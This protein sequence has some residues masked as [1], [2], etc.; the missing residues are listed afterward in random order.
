MYRGLLDMAM[1]QGVR[2]NDGDLIISLWK[3]NLLDFHRHKHN[4]Y[5]IIAHQMLTGMAGFYSQKIRQEMKWNRTVNIRGGEG[6]NIP[7][8]LA[9]E[10]L[11][12]DFKNNLKN[13]NGRYTDVDV[14]RR[15]IMVGPFQKTLKKLF[16]DSFGNTYVYSS[17]GH[18]TNVYQKDVEKFVQ[19]Y[20]EEDLCQQ[21]DGRSHAGMEDLVFTN[22]LENK[23]SLIKRLQKHAN[24]MDNLYRVQH[25]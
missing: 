15:S 17:L 2:E 22:T 7:M 10:F 8:D 12:K 1:H 14:H 5:L 24:S 20:F 16:H 4:K 19:E 3:I 11:N 25:R 13:A 6:N 9:N 18:T 21:I 23:S